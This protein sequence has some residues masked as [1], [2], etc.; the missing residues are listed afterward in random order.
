MHEIYKQMT[1]CHAHGCIVVD[2][3]QIDSS[4]SRV[5]QWLSYSIYDKGV[6]GSSAAGKHAESKAGGPKETVRVVGP[7]P[8]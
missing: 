1:E 2:G 7:I 6:G 4:L 3:M 5:T 8:K